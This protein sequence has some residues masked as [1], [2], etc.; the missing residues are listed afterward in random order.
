MDKEYKIIHMNQDEVNVAVDWAAEE[1]WNPGLNDAPCFYSTDPNGFFAGTLQGTTIAV[2]SA[3][4]YDDHF[5]FCGFYIVDKAYRDQGYG[6]ELTKERL[7]YIGSRNAGIDGVI[8][9]LDK[10]HQLGYEFAHNNARFS[11]EQIQLHIKPNPNIISATKVPFEQLCSY[12]R[13]HFP[14]NR[15]TFLNCWIYQKQAKALCYRTDNQIKGY[16]VIRACRQGFKIGPLFA[17]TPAI[18]DLLFQHLAHYAQ[19]NLL[20][21]DV[22]ETNKHAMELTKKYTMN[23]VFATARMYLKEEPS[24]P[25]EQIYGITSFELG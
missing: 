14:A 6:F 1:G 9:M 3:V 4:I 12:D 25:L 16:G 10:Y 17:N 2:G 18:A 19:G 15:P 24:L 8:T 22:P 13:L 23:K 20:F 5:A 21:L 7:S 11:A